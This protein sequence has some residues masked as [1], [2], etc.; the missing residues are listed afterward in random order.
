MS[1]KTFNQQTILLLVFILAVAIIRTYLSIDQN[2]FGLSN[3]SPIGAMALFSGAYFNKKW[4]AF[5][6]PIVA[7]LISDLTLQFTVHK[8]DTFLYHGWY[9]VYAAFV[10]MVMVGRLLQQIEPLDVF[11]ATVAVTGIHWL[12][13]DFGVWY[14]SHTY[15]QTASGYLQ[16][17]MAAIPFEWRFLAGTLV[18]SAVLF[19]GFE[20]FNRRLT[21]P[22]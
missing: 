11:L 16:C 10:L 13:T 21:V 17:L 19:V 9:Y 20:L 2:M 5:L 15:A 6:F 3:F 7:L 4:K 8:T 12:V 22:A 1:T 14:G 18:Y